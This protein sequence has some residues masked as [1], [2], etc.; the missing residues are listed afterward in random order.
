MVMATQKQE[1]P[2]IRVDQ[3]RKY[4]TSA[5]QCDKCGYYKTWAFK[6]LNPKTGKQVPGHVTKEGFKINDGDCPFYALLKQRANNKT[7]PAPQQAP[8]GQGTTREPLD[9]DTMAPAPA[10]ARVEG[11]VP[12]GSEPAAAGQQSV[13]TVGVERGEIVA[14]IGPCAATLA[15]ADAARLA[16]ALID[17]I[18]A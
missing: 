9:L 14:R 5:G 7:D 16:K 2:A 13:L 6:V 17:A 4:P 18:T 11:R 12:P 1:E 15:R 3:G 10:P 8:Q